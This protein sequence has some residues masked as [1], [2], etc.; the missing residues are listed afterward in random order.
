[1]GAGAV[2]GPF[3]SICAG[4]VIGD[5]VQVAHGVSIAAD[6]HLRDDV[7]LGANVVLSFGNRIGSRVRILSGCFLE[8]VTIEDDV[9]VGPNVTFTNDPYPRSR[10]K[11]P[12]FSRTIVRRGASIGANATILPGLTIG[13]RAMVGAGAVVTRDVPPRAVVAGNPARVLRLLPDDA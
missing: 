12:E 13:E 3:V 6:N 8:L 2:V 7:S 9:F 1:M 11:P 4:S 5:R 10:V